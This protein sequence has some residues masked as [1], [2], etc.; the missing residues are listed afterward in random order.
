MDLVVYHLEWYTQELIL[1]GR[2]GFH[3]SLIGIEKVSNA[4][5]LVQPSGIV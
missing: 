5:Y 1:E 4:C 3:V 2:M